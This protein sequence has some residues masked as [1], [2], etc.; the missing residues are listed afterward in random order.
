[1]LLAARTQQLSRLVRVAGAGWAVLGVA[2]LA[3]GRTLAAGAQGFAVLVALL[4]DHRAARASSEAE[5]AWLIHILCTIAALVVVWVAVVSPLPVAIPAIPCLVIPPVVAYLHSARAATGWGVGSLAIAGGG[6]ALAKLGVLPTDKPATSGQIFGIY[7]VI[8][9]ILAIVAVGSRRAFDEHVAELART[10]E[11]LA[12]QSRALEAQS[13]ALEAKTHALEEQARELAEARDLAERASQAKSTFLATMSH[14]LRTPLS[15]LLGMTGLLD[16]TPLDPEQ[17]RLLATVRASGQSL[18]AIVNDV[19]DEAKLAAGALELAREPFDVQET[20]AS[21]VRLFEASAQ[22]RAIALE[23]ALAPDAPKWLAGDEPRLRQVLSNLVGN[24]VKFTERGRVEVRLERD[25]DGSTVV[26]VRDTGVGIDPTRVGAIFDPFI[27]A[28]ASTTRRFGGTGL[29]L[30]I[31]KRLTEAMGGRIDVESELGV[32]STFRVTVPLERCEAPLRVESKRSSA[33]P[34][35]GSLRVLVVEDDA[36]L[37]EIAHA[38]LVRLGQ[39]VTVAEDGVRGLAVARATAFDVV[40]TD[41]Q[42]PGID[43]VSLWRQLLESLPPERR[44]YGAAMTA[45]VLEEHRAKYAEAGLDFVGK[46]V[47]IEALEAL[48]RR[49]RAWL[50]TRPSG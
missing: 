13:R 21:V 12:E 8:H 33:T 47:S 46:P 27:Q 36:I 6:L 28:D 50:A 11:A 49:A 45:D 20:V 26:A 41:V 18:L 30:S 1:V 10:A 35:V 40:I 39:E 32:G 42:L 24:A 9:V 3:Q 7:A 23:L 38:L 43:G 25:E 34:V 44:P 15:G 31:A 16:E 14:E 37:R 22:Q 5:L 48:L 17:R 19:L 2:N 4:I 29:G